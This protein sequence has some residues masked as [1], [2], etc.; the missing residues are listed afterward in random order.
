MTV[1]WSCR[2]D[3]CYMKGRVIEHIDGHSDIVHK[4]FH[5]YWLPWYKIY[6]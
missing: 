1:F 5:K 2:W 3:F 4:Q 6:D